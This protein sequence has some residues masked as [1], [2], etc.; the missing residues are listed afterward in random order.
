MTTFGN[1]LDLFVSGVTGN[2]SSSTPTGYSNVYEEQNSGAGPDILN[3]FKVVP[4]SG[5]ATGT[6]TSTAATAGDNIG[7]QVGVQ[8]SL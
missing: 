1:E 8:P 2:N 5:T 6:A 7:Y 4:T 3:K